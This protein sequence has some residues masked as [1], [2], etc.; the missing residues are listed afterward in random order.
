MDLPL[1]QVHCELSNRTSAVASPVGPSL[2][3]SR[4]PSL[5][6]LRQSYLVSILD[7]KIAV[8]T[9]E[10]VSVAGTYPARSTQDTSAIS[11]SIEIR[12]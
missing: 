4:T 8:E 11:N 9:H 10:K 1:H 12:V 5:L 7:S 3:D 2:E 6:K